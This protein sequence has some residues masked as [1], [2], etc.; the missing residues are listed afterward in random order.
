VYAIITTGVKFLHRVVGEGFLRARVRPEGARRAEDQRVAVRGG[1][2]DV[3]GPD[4][5]RGTGTCLDDEGLGVF[6]PTEAGGVACI[7]AAL[8]TTLVYRETSLRDLWR[9]CVRSMYLTAQI[10]IVV[11]AAN[12][13]ACREYLHKIAPGF[14]HVKGLI[15]KHFLSS[16]D[17][18]AGGV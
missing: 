8:V 14:Q 9:I 13:S 10:F 3:I 4:R 2:G 12:C 18:W 16:E 7:Y 15:S 6:T 17:G 5:T 11:A 1:L